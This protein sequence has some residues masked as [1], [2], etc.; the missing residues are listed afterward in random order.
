MLSIIVDFC[1][2]DTSIVEYA[3]KINK[4]VSGRTCQRWDSQSPHHHMQDNAEYFVDASLEDAANYCRNPSNPF[5][6]R[7]PWCYTTDV[8]Q[9]REYCDVP[10]C[11][12]IV[13]HQLKILLLIDNVLHYCLNSRWIQQ[14]ILV[15]SVDTYLGYLFNLLLKMEV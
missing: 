11:L 6:P 12:G 10:Y 3:G 7:S 4:T 13:S 2:I 15:N 14:L 1:R 9:Y 5:I 8:N